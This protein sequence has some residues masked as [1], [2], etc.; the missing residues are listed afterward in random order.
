MKFIT[1][2]NKIKKIKRLQKMNVKE[3]MILICKFD[4]AI[5]LTTRKNIIK[6]QKFKKLIMFRIIFKKSKKILKSKDF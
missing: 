6:M 5:T 4:V 2:I 3:I 1:L